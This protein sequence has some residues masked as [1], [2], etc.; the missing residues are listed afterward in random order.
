MSN[1]LAFQDAMNTAVKK[2]KGT[3]MQL[4]V[5][6]PFI[7]RIGDTVTGIR[8]IQNDIAYDN[9]AKPLGKMVDG[10]LKPFKASESV[11]E[12]VT[13]EVVTEPVVEQSTETVDEE[14]VE[15]VTEAEDV[16]EGSEPAEEVT[17]DDGLDEMEL[18][19]LKAFAK[20]IDITF[21][22]NIGADTLRA[23]IRDNAK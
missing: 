19:E 5:D 20:S 15:E 4:N 7:T 13:E 21:A 1:Q 22:T 17:E 3:V 11:V 10:V 8:Y 2:V 12:E 6:K 9:A 23:K 16:A 18:P 14:E